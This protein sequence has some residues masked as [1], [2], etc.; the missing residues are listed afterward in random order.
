V[1]EKRAYPD[2]LLGDGFRKNSLT[3]IENGN[4]IIINN[5][6]N[7]RCENLKESKADLILHPVRMRIIQSLSSQRSLTVQQ[8]AELL[9]DI[10]QAT[11]YRHLNKLHKSGLLS[12]VKK[13][14]IRGAVEKVYALE[15]QAANITHEDM[16]HATPDDH[17]RYFMTYLATLMGDFSRYLAQENFNMLEDGVMYRKATMH[18]S[19]EEFQEFLQDLAA[20]YQKALEKKPSKERKARQIATMIIPEPSKPI[21]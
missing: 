20:V 11:L 18:L 15:E 5:D 7:R 1:Y 3:K 19:D 17:M 14:K 2:I 21:K 13:R 9:P 12:I 16:A 4:I 8:I 6:N 10:P